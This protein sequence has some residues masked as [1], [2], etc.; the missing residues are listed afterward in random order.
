MAVENGDKQSEGSKG[1]KYTVIFSNGALEKLNELAS[2][3]GLTPIEIISKGIKLVDI[4][5]DNKVLRE[6]PDGKRYSIDV[7][8]L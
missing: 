5:K 4:A 6:D 8:E 1:P 2:N 3:F 7:K